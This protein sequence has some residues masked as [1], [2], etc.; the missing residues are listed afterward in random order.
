MIPET[1]SLFRLIYKLLYK[2]MAELKRQLK[3][4]LAK[5]YIKPSVSPYGA[6]VL[7]I[8]KKEGTLQ[9][10]VDYQ[11]LNKITFKNRY[12]LPHIDE[13]LD[14]LVDAKYFTKI[15]LHSGYYQ[16]C[17]KREHTLKTAF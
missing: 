15:N 4:L 6:P 8:Q 9:L 10:C 16:I 12:L 1:E 2:E 17:I 7:F 3:D 5:G 14:K 13:L 11:A